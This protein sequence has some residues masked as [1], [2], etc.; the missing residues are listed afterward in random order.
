MP[1]DVVTTFGWL[2]VWPQGPSDG[3]CVIAVH[4]LT[5][6]HEQVTNIGAALVRDGARFVA[7]DLR[8]RGAS[9][10]NRPGTYGWE[11]HARDV[12]AVADALAIDVFSIV[13]VSM[14][15]SIAMKVA[16]IAGHRLEAVV[17]VDVAGRVDPGVG[18]WIA[19]ALASADPSLVDQ[20]AVDEDRAYTRTQDPYARW[21]HLT[22][23]TLLVRATREVRP[24]SGFVVPSADRDRFADAVAGSVVVE[25]DATHLTIA[26]DPATAN[27]IAAFFR[28]RVR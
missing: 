4:G 16:E 28:G 13:G 2:R 5:S 8:G 20:S 25:V 27:A 11:H 24:G 3:R 18:S 9:A 6:D 1:I 15:A 14:G 10:R 26:N 17:L 21:Q 19:D 12:V 23:P 7:V 22:M